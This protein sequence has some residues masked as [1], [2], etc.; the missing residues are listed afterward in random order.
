MA[1]DCDV[2]EHWVYIFFG[3]GKIKGVEIFQTATERAFR[4]RFRKEKNSGE[5]GRK[6]REGEFPLWL[7]G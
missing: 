4:L 3:C 6:L 1:M 5:Q 2:P 7:S